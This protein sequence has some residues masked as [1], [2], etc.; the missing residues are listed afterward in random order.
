MIREQPVQTTLDDPTWPCP[1]CNGSGR[2]PKDE[3]EQCFMCL[4]ARTLMFDPLD[5]SVIPF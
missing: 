1:A 4:G 2:H 5:F 3:T